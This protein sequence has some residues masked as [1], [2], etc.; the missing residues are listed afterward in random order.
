ML[1]NTFFVYQLIIY[2][3]INICSSGKNVLLVVTS[4]LF[5]PEVSS[6]SLKMSLFCKKNSNGFWVIVRYARKH[7]MLIP[8]A[9]RKSTIVHSNWWYVERAIF[10]KVDNYHE[11]CEEYLKLN[12]NMANNGVLLT[13]QLTYTRNCKRALWYI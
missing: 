4:D 13:F 12:I 10:L 9:I 11:Q 2:Q 8:E 3:Q 7:M 1:F 6:C 5:D